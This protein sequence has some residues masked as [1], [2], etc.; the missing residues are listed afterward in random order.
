MKAEQS[1][2]DELIQREVP[3]LIEELRRDFGLPLLFYNPEEYDKREVMK[4]IALA[5]AKRLDASFTIFNELRLVPEIGYE[6]KELEEGRFFNYDDF[7]DLARK[8]DP[9]L[10]NRE[11]LN[12]TKFVYVR[13]TVI[14]TNARFLGEEYDTFIFTWP[15]VG[16]GYDT[17]MGSYYPIYKEGK[18]M[19]VPIDKEE[20]KKVIRWDD[21]DEYLN[22]LKER[23]KRDYSYENFTHPKNYLPTRIDYTAWTRLMGIRIPIKGR[24][25][26]GKECILG[27]FGFSLLTVWDYKPLSQKSIKLLEEIASIIQPKLTEG[28]LAHNSAQQV[29]KIAALEKRVQQLSILGGFTHNMRN[30]LDSIVSSLEDSKKILKKDELSSE[31]MSTLRKKIEKVLQRVSGLSDLGDKTVDYAKKVGLPREEWKKHYEEFK[32]FPFLDKLLRL[33]ERKLN[34]KGITLKK[35]YHPVPLFDE[36]TKVYAAP[37]LLYSVIENILK[38][39]EEALESSEQ[40][41][42]K[43]IN[44]EVSFLVSSDK[45]WDESEKGNAL[46]ISITD[47]GPGIPDDI[48]E[49]IFRPFFTTKTSSRGTGLGLAISKN[50]IENIYLG[51][52][53]FESVPGKTT[54]MIYLPVNE[55][56]KK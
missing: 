32:F 8:V 46:K 47:S 19:V 3:P 38:N 51:V 39:A 28:Y 18:V 22:T 40:T 48:K 6:L 26:D 30:S 10:K 5:V 17:I 34:Q 25:I 53:T 9:E 24:F 23:V 14:S 43:E 1:I 55:L 45:Y 49:K 31:D 36:N 11:V 27:I 4:G 35:N 20:L 15:L 7:M 12:K 42:K 37:S 2:L 29:K 41:K 13:R 52:L 54:F 44:V 21:A 56:I 50:I 33:Y 16:L